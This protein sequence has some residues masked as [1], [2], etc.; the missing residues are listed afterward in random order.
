MI[1]H[2]TGNIGGDDGERSRR[3]NRGERFTS[4]L[5][6]IE[7]ISSSPNQTAQAVRLLRFAT[8]WLLGA[9]I[10]AVGFVVAGLY[11]LSRQQGKSS[12]SALSGGT[13]SSAVF[14][15]IA[16]IVGFFAIFRIRES[17]LRSKAVIRSEE[18][19]KQLQDKRLAQAEETRGLGNLILANE[20]QIKRYHDIATEQA[21]RSFKSSQHAAWTGLLLVAACIG[22][23]LIIKTADARWFLAGIG[24]TGSALSGFFNRTYLAM[25][26]ESLDQFKHFFDQPVLT[27]YYLTAERMAETIEEKGGADHAL[28]VRREI[29]L[30]I[31]STSALLAESSRT[32]SA[33]IAKV[34]RAKKHKPSSGDNSSHNTPGKTAQRA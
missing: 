30:Q 11:F 20:D 6:T 23:G 28:E 19:A 32:R 3:H 31:L 18:R 10:C 25:Y 24:A 27:S 9:V 13:A 7:R 33:R 15:G 16:S 34:K 26:R 8:A 4:S 2:T 22:A 12:S 29:V 1:G 21:D 17:Y 14:I 5:R